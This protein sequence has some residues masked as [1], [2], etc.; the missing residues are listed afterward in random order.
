MGARV[1][2]RRGYMA[3]VAVHD[4]MEVSP[5]DVGLPVWKC[6]C[7]EQGFLGDYTALVTDE[8]LARKNFEEGVRDLNLHWNLLQIAQ[9][10]G[11]QI[12][13][14]ERAGEPLDTRPGAL[15]E[16]HQGD[17]VWF[18][19]TNPAEFAEHVLLANDAKEDAAFRWK[20]ERV[21]AWFYGQTPMDLRLRQRCGP[22]VGGVCVGTSPREAVPVDARY[23]FP[24]LGDGEAAW[25]LIAWG[26]TMNPGWDDEPPKPADVPAPAECPIC[27]ED[28]HGRPCALTCG[29]ASCLLCADKWLSRTPND[30]DGHPVAVT[31]PVC[32]TE[33]QLLLMVVQQLLRLNFSL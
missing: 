9:Q 3:D 15:T 4:G 18:L 23:T 12:V 30:S 5:A 10:H 1:E 27:K 24:R 11:V 21:P 7:G 17:C 26:A 2:F 16:V 6:T 33:Q 22:T 32:C 8:G 28:L 19:G 14:L 29:H 20:A 31:C 13:Q 25:L